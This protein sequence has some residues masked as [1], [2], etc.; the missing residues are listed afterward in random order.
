MKSYFRLDLLDYMDK[1]MK[2]GLR[3]MVIFVAIVIVQLL[4]F[5]SLL[6]I[7]SYD[8]LV[9][10]LMSDEFLPTIMVFVYS[11]LSLLAVSI[12]L[13]VISG[14]ISIFRFKST[15]WICEIMRIKK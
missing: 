1:L 4:T 3:G 7:Y 12:C 6:F 11:E 2:I 15:D 9:S 10:T 13:I 5:L 14:V 8:F